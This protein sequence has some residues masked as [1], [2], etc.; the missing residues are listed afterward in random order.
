M[1]DFDLLGD[2]EESVEGLIKLIAD[3][4]GVERLWRL[5]D[6]TMDSYF[7]LAVRNGELEESISLMNLLNDFIELNSSIDLFD[8]F[9]CYIV[10]IKKNRKI[11][12]KA[13]R[14][15]MLAYN[16][17]YLSTKLLINRVRSSYDFHDKVEYIKVTPGHEEKPF[18]QHWDLKY[19]DPKFDKD[20]DL[21]KLLVGCCF[22]KEMACNDDYLK[23]I[24]DL[25]LKYDSTTVPVTN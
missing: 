24:F 5:T 6:E 18:S 4:D 17:M 11:H 7:T 25:E 14:T 8:L 16:S 13:H 22:K 3:L 23:Y 21:I 20:E 10:R 2:E 19:T 12:K 1:L 15:Q 9:F